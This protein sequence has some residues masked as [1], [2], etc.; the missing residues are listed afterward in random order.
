M[1]PSQQVEIVK[2]QCPEST[3]PGMGLQQFPQPAKPGF[4]WIGAVYS[5][6]PVPSNALEQD[7]F[8]VST[9]QAVQPEKAFPA[10]R[11][12]GGVLPP[13]HV[14]SPVF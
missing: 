1:I 6:D 9:A 8:C 4:L 11:P 14:I 7:S 13:F 12:Q 2:V 10:G 5:L 3:E